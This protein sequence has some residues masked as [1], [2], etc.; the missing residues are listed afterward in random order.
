[1]NKIRFFIKKQKVL[2]FISKIIIYFFSLIRHG[3]YNLYFLLCSIVFYKTVKLYFLN[4]LTINVDELISKRTVFP[5]P[6][7][8]VIGIYVK[9]GY[10]C[11]IY[12]NVTIGAKNISAEMAQYPTIGNNVVIYANS[13]IIGNV[14][15]GNNV[16]IGAGSVVIKSIPDNCTVVGNPCRIIK[17]SK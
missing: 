9:L 11:K 13:V 2:Y 8:I 17:N 7:G 12:Q 1:M 6:V 15:I 4:H 3:P 16:V 14:H 10:D 5:H